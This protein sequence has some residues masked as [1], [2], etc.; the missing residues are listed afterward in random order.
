VKYQPSGLDQCKDFS[1]GIGMESFAYIPQLEVPS[2]GFPLLA[3]NIDDIDVR[4]IGW[5]DPNRSDENEHHRYDSRNIIFDVA[6]E[7]LHRSRFGTIEQS[8]DR[9]SDR[10]IFSLVKHYP[11]KW[12]VQGNSEG[13]S[14]QVM[15][16]DS[17][18]IIEVYARRGGAADDEGWRRDDDRSDEKTK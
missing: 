11:P 14:N 5:K 6:N 16:N 8:F 9:K 10:P 2:L 1:S 4:L 18:E 15:E 13:E 3:C 17:D 12:A 7:K